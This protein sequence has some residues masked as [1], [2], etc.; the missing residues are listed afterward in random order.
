MGEEEDMPFLSREDLDPQIREKYEKRFK[1]RLKEALLVPG[2]SES[3][4]DHI[5]MQIQS[6]GLPKVYEAEPSE[7]EK[8]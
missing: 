6:L 8:S 4:K 1:S 3:Q 2:I 7:G 5:R